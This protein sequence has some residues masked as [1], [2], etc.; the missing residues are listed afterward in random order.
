VLHEEVLLSMC[1]E[2]QSVCNQ[3]TV[4]AENSDYSSTSA[5]STSAAMLAAT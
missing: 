5:K 2:A 1:A 3:L 4:T